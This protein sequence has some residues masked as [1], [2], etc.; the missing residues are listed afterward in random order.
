[1]R[2]LASET[3]DTC[4]I[5]G[6]HIGN[7]VSF[8]SQIWEHM[9]EWNSKIHVVKLQILANCTLGIKMSLRLPRSSHLCGPASILGNC[10]SLISFWM[11]EQCVL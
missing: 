9:I 1:M 8:E 10:V 4:S 11:A 5:Y 7:I 6:N 2:Q 3:G